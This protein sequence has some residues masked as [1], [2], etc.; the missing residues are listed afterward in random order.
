M[1]CRDYYYSLWCLKQSL[2]NTKSF[3]D[4]NPRDHLAW[5]VRNGIQ[6]ARCASHTVYLAHEN[7]RGDIRVIYTHMNNS[8]RVISNIEGRRV[9]TIMGESPKQGQ[10]GT[11]NLTMMVAE[12]SEE[13]QELAKTISK[14]RDEEMEHHDTGLQHDAEQAPA[15]QALSGAIKIGCLAA[16]WVAERV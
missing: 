11:K 1:H 13:V 5:S 6:N 12:T 3:K 10:T 15:Y 7:S 16:V 4:R 2:V 8:K 14:F 9:G